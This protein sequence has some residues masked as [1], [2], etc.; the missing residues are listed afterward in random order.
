MFPNMADYRKEMAAQQ[1]K[2]AAASKEKDWVQ[3]WGGKTREIGDYYYRLIPVFEPELRRLSIAAQIGEHWGNVKPYNRVICPRNTILAGGIPTLR[4]GLKGHYALLT[5]DKDNNMGL[6]LGDCPIC[7]DFLPGVYSRLEAE[8]AAKTESAKMWESVYSES[9][10]SV[11]WWVWLAECEKTA[12]GNF[13]CN[14]P[15]ELYSISALLF[16]GIVSAYNYQPSDDD[17]EQGITSGISYL[18]ARNKSI[19]E[20]AAQKLVDQSRIDALEARVRDIKLGEALVDFELGYPLKFEVSP[21]NEV[22]GGKV[23]DG[24]KKYSASLY[25]N[26]PGPVP[27]GEKCF[28]S[29]RYGKVRPFQE[30][31]DELYHP[32]YY[33]EG[34]L[35]VACNK[36][37]QARGLSCGAVLEHKASAIAT[38]EDV[39]FGGGEVSDEEIMAEL[40][41][42]TAPKVKTEVKDVKASTESVEDMLSGL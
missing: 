25:L 26:L 17:V 32:E 20:M 14:K 8:R 13:I 18:R 33:S 27:L 11:S 16:Q 6:A 42:V 2:A 1:E 29:E 41:A 12:D 28:T 10:K 36:Y 23:N 38:C 5:E 4:K 37:K 7:R 30:V 9:R 34:S 39:P 24:R 21:D 35:T 19:Y 3:F 40:D 15:A 22:V 31:F